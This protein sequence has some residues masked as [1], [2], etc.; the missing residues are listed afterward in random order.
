MKRLGTRFLLLA[1]LW[2]I[3][4]T[5]SAQTGMSTNEFQTNLILS[6]V[7]SYLGTRYQSGGMS[8]DGI[9][10]IRL[11]YFNYN[12]GGVEIPGTY[13]GIADFGREIKF[14]RIRPGDLVFFE[15]SLPGEDHP[16]VGI[17]TVVDKDKVRFIHVSVS[18]GVIES[19]LLSD[20]YF[21]SVSTYRRVI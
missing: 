7:K 10:G 21:S 4:T 20:Y 12:Q 15:S 1:I 6:S 9:D 2:S 16:N 3:E 13:A 8:R 18:R 19:D 14:K 11:I 5:A 17:I